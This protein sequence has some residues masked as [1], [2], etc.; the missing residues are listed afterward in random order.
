MMDSVHFIQL[1]RSIDLQTITTW[2]DGNPGASSLF[3]ANGKYPIEKYVQSEDKVECTR[4]DTILANYN[5]DKV[6][7]VWM[8]LQG[9]E[10]LAIES[11]GKYIQDVDFI[12]TEVTF[13]VPTI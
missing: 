7:I 13:T 12:H 2:V 11:F 6:D 8:D 5:V 1:I 3:K 4:V 9:A 10:K